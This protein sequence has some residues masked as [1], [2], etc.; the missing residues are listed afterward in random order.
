MRAYVL[1]DPVQD[2]EE[3]LEILGVFGTYRGAE[4]AHEK[5]RQVNG[6]FSLEHYAAGRD[7]EIQLWEGSTLLKRWQTQQT[8][9]G[10]MMENDT[11]SYEE[12]WVYEFEWKAIPS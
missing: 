11:Y 4:L 5:T 3:S 6:Y 10:E 8:N 9:R 1:V 2:Y 7:A 12:G